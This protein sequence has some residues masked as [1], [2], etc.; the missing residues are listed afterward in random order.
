L[1]WLHDCG[2]G[3]GHGDYIWRELLSMYYGDEELWQ[4]TMVVVNSRGIMVGCGGG[5]DESQLKSHS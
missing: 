3:D 2:H 1:L 5:Y 4:W